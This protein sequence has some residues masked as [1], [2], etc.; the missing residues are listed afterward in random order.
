MVPVMVYSAAL[1]VMAVQ[2]LDLVLRRAPVGRLG[3]GV[4]RRSCSWSATG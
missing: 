1:L 4:G 2:A 3:G